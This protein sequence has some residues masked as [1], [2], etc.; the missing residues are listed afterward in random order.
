MSSALVVHP[1]NHWLWYLAQI[2]LGLSFVAPSLLALRL[3]LATGFLL[4]LIWSCQVL[5]VGVDAAAF[6]GTHDTMDSR[7]AR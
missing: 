3:L 7:T 2:S 1:A 4:L 5:R 6:A